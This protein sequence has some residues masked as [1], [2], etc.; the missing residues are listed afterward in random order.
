MGEITGLVAPSPITAPISDSEAARRAGTW[1][2]VEVS[3]DRAQLLADRPRSFPLFYAKRGKDWIVGSNAART[4]AAAGLTRRSARGEA[5]LL[6]CGHTLG[7]D[8]LFQNLFTVPAGSRVQLEPNGAVTQRAFS[9]FSY[10]QMR[11]SDDAT[12]EEMFSAAMDMALTRAL[13]VIGERRIVLPLS[14][15]IDSR[16]L[17]A[18]LQRLG[19]GKIIAFT[20]GKADAHEVTVSR[21]V[22]AEAGIEWHWVETNYLDIAHHWQSSPIHDFLSSTWSGTALPHVQDWWALTRL[23]ENSILEPG[24]VVMPG[25]TVVGNMHHGEVLDW[26]DPDS[27]IQHAVDSHHWSLRGKHP[28]AGMER[29]LVDEAIASAK[30]EVGFDGSRAATQACIEWFG[31]R[32]RQAKYINNSVRAYEYFGL[33]WAMP[34]LDPELWD[35]CMVGDEAHSVD[36]GWYAT[37]TNRIWREAT[38]SELAFHTA[39][40]ISLPAGARAFALSILRKTRGDR[41]LSRYRSVRAQQHHPMAFEAFSSSIP[42]RQS[43]PYLAGGGTLLGL[44]SQLFLDNS[45]GNQ[46]AIVPPR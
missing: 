36:R 2:R 28:K 34:M 18:W 3:E 9:R 41:V 32:E 11:V 1:T 38:G 39:P 10:P 21:Q 35:V 22:A 33:E 46:G 24:D 8:T 27:A 30:Q 40:G 42:S 37:L 23:T 17:L 43:L 6:H 12:Y 44:W 25:H 13:N 20:Y 15:G 26:P 45:W 19:A 16:L 14:G 5:A 4:A 7:P 31:A 29:T